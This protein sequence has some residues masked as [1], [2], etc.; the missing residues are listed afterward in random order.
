[1]AKVA[2]ILDGGRADGVSTL[3][4]REI[5]EAFLREKGWEVDII[6]L[7]D[8]RIAPCMGCF[9]CWVKTPGECVVDDAGR[10]VARRV[11]QS[12]LVIYLT[13]VLFGGYSPEL[14]K[15]VD[16]LIP[17]ILPFFRRVK[18]EVHHVKRYARSARLVGIGILPDR[19][20]EEAEIFETLVRRNAINMH[21]PAVEST[22]FCAT[23][24]EETVVRR[25]EWAL[26]EVI[27]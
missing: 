12:D 1:M 19:N 21:A 17:N 27:A 26:S 2:R 20:E 14:K 13:P 11:V 22:V 4:A 16:R 7:A 25:I 3:R 10:D 6:R 8:I 18:G 5:A 15:A 24:I 9:G 23:D